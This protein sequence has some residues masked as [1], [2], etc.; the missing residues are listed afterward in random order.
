MNNHIIDLKDELNIKNKYSCC[1]FSKTA[2]NYNF[3]P[4]VWI[5]L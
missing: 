1:R 3:C 4:S 2:G 5:D